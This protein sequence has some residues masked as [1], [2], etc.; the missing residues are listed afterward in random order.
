[1]CRYVPRGWDYRVGAMPGK[2]SASGVH[3][4]VYVHLYAE[5]K[6]NSGQKRMRGPGSE[7]SGKMLSTACFC[8][9]MTMWKD[10]LIKFWDR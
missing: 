1:M 5:W 3:P 8:Y 7:P 9:I 6:E 10:F 2:G 4:D